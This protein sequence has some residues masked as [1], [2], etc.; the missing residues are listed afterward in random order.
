MA[1]L[2]LKSNVM[3]K[4]LFPS[5]TGTKTDCLFVEVSFIFCVLIKVLWLTSPTGSSK[6]LVHAELYPWLL[7]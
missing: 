5:L 1:C 7:F 3:T 4:L 6:W 2:S